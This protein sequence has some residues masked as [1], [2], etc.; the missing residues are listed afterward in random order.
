MN[1]SRP[2]DVLHVC[3]RCINGIS[4]AMFLHDY[5]PTVSDL[6]ALIPKDAWDLK[7][8]GT[9][10]IRI[11]A[12][13]NDRIERFYQR[14]PERRPRTSPRRRVPPTSSHPRFKSDQ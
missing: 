1:D 10:A 13:Y 5:A 7:T 3:L 9:L 2:E 11:E 14:Y 8:R 4:D 6:W 12:A